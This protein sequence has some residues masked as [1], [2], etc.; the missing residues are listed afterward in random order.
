MTLRSESLGRT[1]IT[2][3]F[4]DEYAM[5]LYGYFESSTFF[6]HLTFYVFDNI[7]PGQLGAYGSLKD[8]PDFHTDKL[9]CT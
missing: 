9:C 7:I 1:G 3:S 6:N 5:V 4:L 2:V 8:N